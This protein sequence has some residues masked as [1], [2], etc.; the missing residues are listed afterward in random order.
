[1]IHKLM[2]EFRIELKLNDAA[3]LALLLYRNN[4]G[5]LA[6]TIASGEHGRLLAEL[7][8][9][10]DVRFATEIDSIPVLPVLKNRKIVL[11]EN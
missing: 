4:S 9:A 1:L 3:S 8:F 5:S 2:D 11:E 10:D 6:A 7:G